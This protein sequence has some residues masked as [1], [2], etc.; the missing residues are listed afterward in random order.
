M[1][2]LAVAVWLLLSHLAM[3]QVVTV[4]SG[5]HDGFSRLV[6]TF[7]EPAG[8][9]LGRT[10]DGY[11]FRARKP[12]WRYD[13]STVFDLIPRDR[14]AALWV[15][16]DSGVLRLGIGCACHAVATPFRPGIVV[17]DILDG[18]APAGSPYETALADAG[19]ALPPLVA[20]QALRPRPRPAGLVPEPVAM[21]D[22]MTQEKSAVPAF[23]PP[24]VIASP[25]PRTVAMRDQLLRDLSRG[26]AAG[27]IKPT[28]P[29]PVQ[30][31]P[32]LAAGPTV[33]PLAPG[34]GAPTQLRVRPSDALPDLP[35]TGSGQPCIADDRLDL[36]AWGDGRHPLV[37]LVSAR[38]GL[39]G[40]FDRPD[41]DRLIALVRLHLYLGFGAE[42]RSLMRLWGQDDPEAVVLDSLGLLV[43]GRSGALA[44]A[45][46]QGCDT[47]A[48]LWSVL[49]QAAPAA[50]PDFN[51]AAVLR[52]FS[53]LPLGL[54]RHLGPS[55]SDRAMAVGDADSA[56]AVR[57]AI[58]RAPGPHGDGLALI[59][60]RL[61]LADGRA[62]VAEQ[63]LE[64]IVAD[65]G[66]AA[67]Q[68]LATL[69][70]TRLGRGE[71]PEASQVL[72]LDAMMRERGSTTDAGVLR[73]ALAKGLAVTGAAERAFR[74]L[75]PEDPALYPQL[76]GLLAQQGAL[77]DLAGLALDPPAGSQAAVPVPVRLAIAE[78]LRSGG[79]AEGAGRWAN[80]ANTPEADLLLARVALDLRDG[81]EALR[82]LAGQ[83]GTA[84]EAL[85]ARSL[86]LLGDLQ[87]AARAWDAAGSPEDAERAR[88]LDRRWDDL[89]STDLQLQE[90]LAQRAN[91][92]PPQAPPLAQARALMEGSLAVRETV[93]TV[94]AA[95][96]FPGNQ[97]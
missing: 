70:E 71:V 56:R 20:R 31:R 37:Q 94:L 42:A 86:E 16:P 27:A 28:A 63:R 5:Q 85:R 74:E 91:P 21:P 88:F 13:I 11:G 81:R 93:G 72:A 53:A 18:A 43:D 41:R 35:L 19:R 4:R 8:W 62:E 97:P 29:L 22:L 23:A 54:R 10:L 76:W 36:A 47:A 49:S 15:D 50:G 68:A 14:L 38:S 78:R 51:R 26:I 80:G 25:D 17:V 75:A 3:A 90:L 32:Q 44:F 24:L 77:L 65:D 58:D 73:Q 1:L 55:L 67:A 61:D 57:D 69:I 46:M 30:D 39:L 83:T 2:R 60:A 66:A 52:A 48:A 84:A 64:T 96:P 45:G 79:F 87:G 7:P 34:P 40:E 12:G 6:L 9:D 59:E 95:R 92:P 89:S 33:L 82:H